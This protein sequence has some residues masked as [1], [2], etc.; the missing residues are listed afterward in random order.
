MASS[1][2]TCF[3][4]KG[5]TVIFIGNYM[6][7]YIPKNYF[8]S[9]IATFIADKVEIFGIFLFKIFKDEE[10]KSGGSLHT[11]SLPTNFMTIP[12]NNYVSTLKLKDNIREDTYVVLQYRK[13]DIF[14]ENEELLANSEN[15][16]K[17]IKLSHAG[18]IPN[19]IPYNK[20]L[21]LEYDNFLI[22]DQLF[23]I[24]GVVF[25][26]CQSEINRDINDI[27]QPFRFKAG[28]KDDVDMNAYQPISIKNIPTFSSTFTAITFEDI[29]AALITSVNKTRYGK[30]EAESPI[31]KTIKY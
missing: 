29:D 31:E 2:L 25:E 30:G 18:K 17:F 26:V 28:K 12:S 8:T 21:K 6:E 7:V 22:N 4:E 3:Q 23:E 20:V 5:N 9:N 27:S 11:Y 16:Q 1:K 19:F 13:G 24:P 14:I 10:T 15:V